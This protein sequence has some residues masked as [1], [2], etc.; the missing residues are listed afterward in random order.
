MVFQTFSPKVN[1]LYA[2]LPKTF[3]VGSILENASVVAVK[4]CLI[5][6]EPSS[7][8]CICHQI[9][10]PLIVIVK[11]LG[12]SVSFVAELIYGRYMY[13]EFINE[14][15]SFVVSPTDFAFFAAKDCN[16][17]SLPFILQPIAVLPMFV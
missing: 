11:S 4:T 13:A 8:T 6:I 10:P 15:S 9:I 16:A 2:D 14:A 17:D 7:E 5:D 3:E 12:P 1:S